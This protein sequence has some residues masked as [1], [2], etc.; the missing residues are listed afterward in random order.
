MLSVLKRLLVAVYCVRMLYFGYFFYR[1]AGGDALYF[2]IGVANHYILSVQCFLFK[3][4]P[5]GESQSVLD[6]LC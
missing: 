5:F 4:P 6:F 1:F 3:H 2:V